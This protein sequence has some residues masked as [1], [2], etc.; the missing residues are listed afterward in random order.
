[1][2]RIVHAAVTPSPFGPPGATSP[3]L[4]QGE[5]AL[6]APSPTMPRKVASDYFRALRRGSWL[7]VTV[8]S[9]VIAPGSV[10]VARQPN[11]YRAHAT[12]RIEPPSFDERVATI[13]PHAEVGSVSRETQEKYVPNLLAE[14]RGRRLAERAAANTELHLP[15]EAIED[16]VN[17]LL[18]LTSRRHAD[19]NTF[20]V[21]LEWTDQERVATL[22]NGLLEEFQQSARTESTRAITHSENM[23]AG[24][25]KVL[26]QQL[27]ELK[28]KIDTAMK[29]T[30]YLTPDGKN[31]LFD[32]QLQVTTLLMQKRARGDELA[33]QQRSFQFMPQHRAPQPHPH[34]HEIDHLL[35]LKDRYAEQLRNIRRLSRHPDRD[36]AGKHYTRLLEKT[37]QD[38]EYLE[39]LP[40][41]TDDNSDLLSQFMAHHQ[42]DVVKLE[43]EVKDIQAE[44]QASMP[45]YQGFLALLD[46]RER[47]QNSHDAMKERLEEFRFLEN[48]SNEPVT[49]LQPAVEPIVPVRPKRSLTLA[50]VVVLGLGLGCGLVCLLE[51]TDRRVKAPDQLMIGLSLPLL[52]VVP[53]IRRVRNMLRGGHLWT[54]GSP[55]SIEA[56]AFRNVR[57]SLLGSSRRSFVTLLV[58]SARSSEGKSTT[59]LN[60]AATCA[61]AGERTLLMEVDLRRPS[62]GPVFGGEQGLGLVD[63][64]RGEAPWQ[65]AVVRTDIPNLD[66]LPCGDPR[67]V[68]VEVLGTLEM[69]QLLAAVS[70]HYHRVILDG[71][72]VLGLA[73]SRTLGRMVDASILVVR[74]G[75]SDLTPLQRAKAMLELSSVL[76]AGVVF[77]ALTEDFT[78]WSS[79]ALYAPA[80]RLALAGPRA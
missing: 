55:E 74:S 2:D 42:E 8:A 70:G 17:V 25:L 18:G 10:Y 63:A 35:E 9:L 40:V 78:N 69:R 16:A 38:L 60:L 71:P 41:A 65:K 43:R 29:D 44:I 3:A 13:V 6:G 51:M 73:D 64:L 27:E 49:I 39:S 57:A 67:G 59:A 33:Q 53:R 23:A 37:V 58:T 45:T 56:D 19:S 80:P 75:A 62:L 52:G 15:P 36:P 54:P 22:L 61:L 21:F 7:A 5:M 30:P 20:D 31:T 68:P 66:V 76:I 12:I 24:N 32:E 47:L 14:L 1:M 28:R 26:G 34:Q 72:A 4:N 77:N 79:Q 11:V 46:E 48:S 50:L